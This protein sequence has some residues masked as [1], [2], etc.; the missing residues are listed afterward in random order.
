M[1]KDREQGTG[2]REQAPGQVQLIPLDLLDANPKNPRRTMN[3]ATLAELAASIKATGINQPILARP[4]PNQDGLIEAR[5][6]IICGHRRAEAATLA[7]LLEVPVIVREMTDAEAAEI[8]LV[9]NLQREDVGALEEAEAFGAL[10]E[11]HGTVEAVAARVGKD[12]PHVAKRLKLISLGAWQR[13]S[14]RAKLITVDHALLLARL[15]HADQDQALKW[16]LDRNAGVKT[17]VDR[18]IEN[19]KKSL[20]KGNANKYFG[21]Y[22]EPQSVKQLKEHIE[23]SSG[24]LLSRAPW[25]LDDA[26]LVPDAGACSNCPSNTKANAA[27]FDDLAIEKATCADGNCFEAKREVFVQIALDRAAKP[28]VKLSWKSSVSEP[29]MELGEP[30][31]GPKGIN[32]FKRTPKLTQIFRYGQWLDVKK[33]SCANVIQGVAIDWSDTDERGYGLSDKKL[34]KPGEV[35]FVCVAAKCKTHPKAWENQQR[36]AA[37]ERHDPAAEKAAEEKKKAEAIAE[38]KMRMALAGAALEDVKSVP[39]DVL[40]TLAMK[41]AK[42]GGGKQRMVDALLPG[43]KK[44]LRTA[45]IYSSEFAKAVAI[46]SLDELEPN[47]YAG[48]LHGRKHFIASIRRLGYTGPLPWDEQKKADQAAKSKAAKP[49]AKSTAK[50]AAPKGGKKS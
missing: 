46:A 26:H 6:E 3:E 2:N 14:L 19:C 8:A 21:Y 42:F 12:V 4:A 48:P 27:L 22:W 17:P 20:A 30:C 28:V 33:E 5:Y 43:L 45:K 31:P 9:D 11:L 24:R 25:N 18:V 40:R 15:G 32:N 29:R 47:Q 23:Q 7:G 49:A 41:A 1:T 10:L 13:D 50:K 36:R 35:L 44:T 37:G 34:R 39:S 16:C 38:G